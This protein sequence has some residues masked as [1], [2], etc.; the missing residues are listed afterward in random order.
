MRISDWSSD[1]CSSD[2]VSGDTSAA[3]LQRL[4]FTLDGLDRKPDLVI[5]G[6]GANDMLRGLSPRATRANLEAILTELKKR[7][8]PTML[9]GMVAAPTMGTDRSEER[10]VG[11]EGVRTCKFRW[12]PYHYTRNT[13]N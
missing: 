4:A 8:I 13:H 2:L 10:R 9:T 11:K 5:V 6:L 1:V 12:P 3:G 7:D